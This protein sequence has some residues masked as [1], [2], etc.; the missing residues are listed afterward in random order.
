MLRAVRMKRAAPVRP[1]IFRPSVR[2]LPGPDP[3]AVTRARFS[4]SRS[5]GGYNTIF[6]L[7]IAGGETT[8]V[9]VVDQQ[10]DPVRAPGSTRTSSASILPS[11]SVSRFRCHVSGEPKGVKVQGGMLEIVTRAVEIEC[12]PDDIPESFTVDVTELLIGQSKRA[13][14]SRCRFDEVAQP[15]RP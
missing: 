3:V 10:V 14:E 12:L 13:S 6:T 15:R 8:P 1:E 7:A 4:R 9:M 11:A 2:R 5:D